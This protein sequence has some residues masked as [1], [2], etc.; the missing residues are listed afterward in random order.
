VT[1]IKHLSTSKALKDAILEEGAAFTPEMT[2]KKIR[3]FE[4]AQKQKLLSGSTSYNDRLHET[5][6]RMTS[7]GEE[8]PELLDDTEY[9]VDVLN[10]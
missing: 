3:K 4:D 6:D 7:L 5:L 10:C 8:V 9:D 1:P 2:K